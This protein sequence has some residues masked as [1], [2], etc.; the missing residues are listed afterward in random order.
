M[1]NDFRSNSHDLLRIAFLIEE[2][3]LLYLSSNL[4]NSSVHTKM[5]V[6]ILQT[7]VDECTLEKPF[8]PHLSLVIRPFSAL[9]KSKIRIVFVGASPDCQP[10]MSDGLLFSYSGDNKV[11][12]RSQ[13]ILQQVN[14]TVK[15]S[16]NST[17]DLSRWSRQ[18][19]LLLPAAWTSPLYKPDGH[20]DLWQPFTTW[21]ISQLAEDPHLLWVFFGQKS[22]VY[23]KL[24]PKAGLL[25]KVA[26]PLYTVH[27]LADH[28][29]CSDLFNKVNRCLLD[30]HEQE[31]V[32]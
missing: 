11:P 28:W 12:K 27:P 23:S 15:Q 1:D 17:Y 14:K 18:G 26:D 21:L 4:D 7:L 10:F 30:K 5:L 29:D 20:W 31:I 13:R 3:M 8:T 9:E 25:L 22:H 19:V 6:D 16:T 2:Q 24:I 32:W